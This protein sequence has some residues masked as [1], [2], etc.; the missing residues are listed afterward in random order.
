MADLKVSAR[1]GRAP[2]GK[3]FRAQRSL[4]FIAV[5]GTLW[6]VLFGYYP[7]WGSIIAFKN[8]DFALGIIG[9]PW[10]GLDHFR[11]FFRDSD[12]W[13]I[14]RNT[15]CISLLKLAFAF[16]A[17]IILAL[18]LNELTST[19]YKKLVQTVTYLPHFVSWVI[20]AG[21]CYQLLSPSLG[22]VIPFLAKLG[23]V[24]PNL[25]IL[26]EPRYFW[27]VAVVTDIWKEVGWNAVIYLAAITAVDPTLFEAAK[28]DGAGRWRQ[29]WSITLP[30]IVPTVV[31][32]LTLTIGNLFQANFDQ[33]WLLRN[34]AIVPTAEVIDTH[35]FVQGIRLG[36]YDYATAVGLFKSFVS[37]ALLVGANSVS[38][39][40]VRASI[41]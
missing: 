11:E 29:V 7:M 10:A 36:R 33:I 2:L 8:F 9:S 22:P 3:R 32:M 28:I 27:G 30:C 25:L 38:R 21:L 6:F 1:I 40:L 5:V 15:L 16:P 18:L 20:V 34:D 13:I 24:D 41:W 23:L 39:R 14:M 12:F 4:F 31:V 37:V 19:G 26:V 35:V 17:P